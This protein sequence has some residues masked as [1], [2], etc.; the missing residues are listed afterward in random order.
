[1]NDEMSTLRRLIFLQSIL[2]GPAEPVISTVVGTSPLSLVN[3]VAAQ[4]IS[5]KRFGVCEQNGTPSPDSPAFIVCNNGTL[6]MVD[7]ELPEGYKRIES[8]RFDGKTHYITNEKLF[9][10]DEITITLDDT[11]S[12]GQNVFGSYSGTASGR[13]NYSLYIYGG[14]S[15]TSSYLRYG[16]TL[17]RPK[18]GDGKRTLVYGPNGASGFSTGISMTP[19]EFETDDVAWI[20]ML[21]NSSS[22]HFTGTIVGSVL[23]S[24]RLKY[25]PC[26]R[27][28]DGTIGYYEPNTEVFLEPEGNGT[29]TKGAYDGSHYHLEV[30]GTPETVTV[31]LQTATVVDL[32]GVGGYAD[33]QDIISGLVTRRV[34]IRVLGGTEGWAMQSLGYSTDAIDGFP[35]T[36]FIP[37]CSHFIGVKK[38]PS[39]NG[40]V[41]MYYGSGDVAQCCFYVDGANF[42]S[43]ES[44]ETFLSAQYAEGTPVIIVYPLAEEVPESVAAQTLNLAEGNNTITSTANV[45]NIQLEAVYQVKE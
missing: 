20:G 21:P 6:K 24:N 44:W 33:T 10:S 30:V 29:P 5:L 27:I 7:D 18:Y 31:G 2:G 13:K 16:E 17:Y 4:I 1:M 22:P 45:S 9:G 41:R 42:P 43:V 32:F 36:E 11:A 15:S 35:S 19:E 23:I 37:L 8:I 28:S 3:A 26:E 14:G 12:G 38:T 39:Q 40:R 34:G 25:I